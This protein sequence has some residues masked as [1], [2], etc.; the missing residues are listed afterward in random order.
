METRTAFAGYVVWLWVRTWGKD[1][2]K[3]RSP[4]ISLPPDSFERMLAFSRLL[5]LL[6]LGFRIVF[7]SQKFRVNQPTKKQINRRGSTPC[8][9]PSGVG[10]PGMWDTRLLFSAII[11]GYLIITYHL[12]A[13]RSFSYL[14]DELQIKTMGY[15]RDV[16]L[17]RK[18][19]KGSC[20]GNGRSLSSNFH[21]AKLIS[22]AGVL[23]SR[24][25]CFRMPRTLMPT[26]FIQC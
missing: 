8:L 10:C 11:F 15:T 7:V 1:P 3:L 23:S 4:S 14:A 18:N 2:G 24:V 26:P 22:Q 16:S 9:G 5:L 21:P 6:W 25:L 12:L 17:G 13:D 19:G 20:S